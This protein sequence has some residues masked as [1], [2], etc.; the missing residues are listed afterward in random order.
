MKVG[1]AKRKVRTATGK[2]AVCSF[3][4]HRFPDPGF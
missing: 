2:V 3:W 1:R 4:A